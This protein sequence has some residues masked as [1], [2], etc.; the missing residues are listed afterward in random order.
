M[1]ATGK[2]L[3]IF[4]ALLMLFTA[5]PFAVSAAGG[6]FAFYLMPSDIQAYRYGYDLTY[7]GNSFNAW[8]ERLPAGADGQQIYLARNEAEGFQ[9]YFTEY[10]NTDDS[11]RDLRVTVDPFVNAAGDA[12]EC[13][14]FR[15][16]YMAGDGMDRE[17]FP[18]VA[19]A[20]LPYGGEAVTTTP[21]DNM[22]FYVEL[23]AGKDQSPGD[24]RSAVKLYEG[25]T[26]LA[27]RPITATVWHFALP[28][29]HY[30]T[31]VSGLYNSNSG[32]AVTSGFLRACGVR[33]TEEARLKD[34]DIIPEDRALAEEIL[35]AW[36]EVLLQHGIST[37][38]IPR[39]LLDTDEKAAE[40]TMADPRRKVFAVPL[41]NSDVHNGAFNAETEE[42]ILRYKELVY[43]N[44]FLRDKAYF[45]P[46]DE[47]DWSSGMPDE[48]FSQQYAEIQRLWP[49]AHVTVPMNSYNNG[50][51]SARRGKTDILCMSQSLLYGNAGAR[52][53]F[54]D[55]TWFRTWRYPDEAQ[56]GSFYLYTWAKSPMGVYHR[57]LYW[58]QELLHSD[59][60]LNWNCAYLPV[61]A[62]GSV[63]NVWENDT[64]PALNKVNGDGILIYPGTALG[65]PATEPVVSLRMKQIVS[66]LDD[67]DY[68]QLTK[69]F[70]G[71]DSEA[72]RNAVNIVFPKYRDTGIDHI[73]S[74]LDVDF[75][76]WDALDMYNAR[77][78]LGT[79]LDE[80]WTAGN[81]GHTY[82]D[83]AVAV[84]P[85]E[86]HN[87]L[88]IRT[89]TNCGAQESKKIYLC[90]DGNHDD[91]VCTSIDGITHRV[92]CSVCGR[93]RTE[94][95]T[96]AQAEGRAPTCTQTGWNAYTYC[97]KCD[98][99]TCVEIPV[100]A[101][102][103]FT[104]ELGYII[105][106]AEAGVDCRH[107]GTQAYLECK[108]CHKLFCCG[109]LHDE[110]TGGLPSDGVY[111]P[112]SLTEIAP[113]AAA[114]ETEGNVG[115]WRCS[116]CGKC[117]RDA[118]G[119]QEIAQAQTIIAAKG[120][121]Y[122]ETGR[123][124]ATCT[125]EGVIYYTCVNDERHT[126]TVLIGKT[127][128]RDDDGDGRCDVCGAGVDSAEP[129]AENAGTC[130]YCGGTHAGFWG[131]IVA[132]FHTIL[133]FFAHLFGRR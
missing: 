12:L 107:T 129:A 22:M 53:D 70:L 19:E 117:F 31:T 93:S 73:W 28:E 47:Q 34:E 84:E 63:Y 83:W 32:Y 2:P 13:A 61:N 108:E 110:I 10:N 38:E 76:S 74:A 75:N 105:H 121:N 79:A 113:K 14:V 41:L 16:I 97:T 104:N 58:Q 91:S 5:L 55:G 23:R 7:N 11:V 1:K 128:H 9:I 126:Q 111:G 89:C 49:E 127:G 92:T 66:G 130:S 54:T 86:T 77:V 52:N 27:T 24:Y 4:L 36:Q 25:D 21:N 90:D 72:Y 106:N 100:L 15:E 69:E 125:Q 85:D 119:T 118:A 109:G 37:Y 122:V 26:V 64:I 81:T 99:T 133:Y 87:G 44:T 59:G 115:F 50:N 80:A 6:D 82:T 71:E 116:V 88:A 62:D 103:D 102:H 30:A 20:L 40:L 78:I 57:I 120:H 68:F 3:A 8:R 124:D 29:A 45:Y 94:T 43:D 96:L 132:F 42:N 98:Y 114:C 46:E 51:I 56:L 17:K 95:H 123:T 48:R 60:M 33:F 65:L 101:T 67:Y 131:K 35:E 18:Y 39:Y 112:H